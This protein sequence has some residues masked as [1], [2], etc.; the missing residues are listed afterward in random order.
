MQC[1]LEVVP[2]YRDREMRLVFRRYATLRL[3][4][5]PQAISYPELTWLFNNQIKDSASKPTFVYHAKYIYFSFIDT[6]M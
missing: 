3:T 4:E 2:N 6:C 1:V 5:Q